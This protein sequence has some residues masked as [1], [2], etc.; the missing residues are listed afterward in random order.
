MTGSE[1]APL[2]GTGPSSMNR[3]KKQGALWISLCLVL[4]V[5]IGILAAYLIGNKKE[6][7]IQLDMAKSSAAYIFNHTIESD[8]LAIQHIQ[9]ERKNNKM[10]DNVWSKA[11]KEM[12]MDPP[13]GLMKEHMFA[14]YAY[15]I[16]NGS[17]F[18]RI[19]NEAMR[20]YGASDA[21][22]AKNFK[23][24]G[25]HYLLSVAMQTL[26]NISHCARKTTYRGFTKLAEAQVGSEI[27]F[28]YF[29][30]SSFSKKVALK[31]TKNTTKTNTFLQIRSQFG[32][33]IQNYSA[34]PDEQ[35]VLI[36][37]DEVFEVEQY[38]PWEY[39]INISLTA[40]RRNGP[41]V[42]L[43]MDKNGNLVAVHSEGATILT[44]GRL[45]ILALLVPIWV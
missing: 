39:G 26:N 22:Y 44:L 37:P 41:L 17:N 6:N 45:W 42:N 34:V 7:V 27:R 10:F 3:R 38:I 29:A 23:F 2:R 14:V 28:G 8:H 5:I 32:V 21:I 20:Q 35:E 30:S 13:S 12:T 43:E 31:F 16:S 4:F 40:K 36:P 25:F 24:I 33:P 9:E 18:F 11:T 19:F 1:E 15:T